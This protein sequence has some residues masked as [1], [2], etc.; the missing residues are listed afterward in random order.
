MMTIQAQKIQALLF[1]TADQYN[2]SKISNILE[3]PEN[4]VIEAIENLSQN[5]EGQGITLLNDGK[6]IKLVTKPEFSN[7]IEKIRKDEL[8][9]DLSKASAETL[10]II[11]YRNGTSK[12]EIEL[13]RGVNATYSLRSLQMR[14][15]IETRGSGRMIT[16]HPTLT[17]LEYFGIKS[18]EELPLFSETKQ[19]IETLLSINNKE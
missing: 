9:K 1:A 7:I 2:I 16:Y 5:L 11:L 19:K 15:L 14:G 10:S 13:I 3:I 4:E 6:N 17:L 8:S 12:A 18:I